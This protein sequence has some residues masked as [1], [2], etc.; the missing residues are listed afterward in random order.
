MYTTF[1]ILWGWGVAQ[2]VGSLDLTT[3]TSLSPIRRGFAPGFVNSKKKVH[4]TRSRK[5][6][7]LSV[8]FPWSVVLSGYSGFLH[9]YNWSPRYSWTIVESGAKTPTINKKSTCYVVI[10]CRPWTELPKQPCVTKYVVNLIYNGYIEHTSYYA[11]GYWQ[12]HWANELHD[13]ILS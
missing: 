4:S 3:H 9:H 10:S 11:L 5:W 6:Y 8:A 1:N 7:S 2:W 13:C 12:I